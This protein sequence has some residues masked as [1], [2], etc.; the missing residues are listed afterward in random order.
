MAA[1]PESIR[2]GPTVSGC[3]VP[4][5]VKSGNVVSA[6]AGTAGAVQPFAARWPR[7]SVS[8]Q[9]PTSDSCAGL[10]PLSSSLPAT[11][12]ATV[13]STRRTPR[14]LHRRTDDIIR[15]APAPPPFGTGLVAV[16]QH[17]W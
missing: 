13:T 8:G 15:H 3:Q 17:A 5:G 2:R 10:H 9:T 12:P 1:A 14:P 4:G 7:P 11:A 16:V 6:S